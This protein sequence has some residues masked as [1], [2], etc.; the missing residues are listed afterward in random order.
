MR[1]PIHSVFSVVDAM[2]P[3]GWMPLIYFQFAEGKNE[4]FSHL[5]CA[6]A[7]CVPNVFLLYIQLKAYI[8]TY[9]SIFLKHW[10]F[11]WDRFKCK[12]FLM[13]I[14][15]DVRSGV[16]GWTHDPRGI[17]SRTIE[18]VH[19]R[20]PQGIQVNLTIYASVFCIVQSTIRTPRYTTSTQ[21]IAIDK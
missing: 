16:V 20:I 4:S 8:I 2:P 19:T 1:G 5:V 11:C 10:I 14:C 17:R 3:M 21:N 13:W 12:Q 18:R 9:G 7:V 15:Q 6:R